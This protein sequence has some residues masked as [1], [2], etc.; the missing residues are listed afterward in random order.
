MVSIYYCTC[1]HTQRQGFWKEY[2]LQTPIPQTPFLY[3]QIWFL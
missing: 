1:S 2:F 3:V